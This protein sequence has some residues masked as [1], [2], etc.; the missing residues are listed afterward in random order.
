MTVY[1]R[2]LWW[3][4]WIIFILVGVPGALVILRPVWLPLLRMLGLG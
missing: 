4:T 2:R 1:H 3:G